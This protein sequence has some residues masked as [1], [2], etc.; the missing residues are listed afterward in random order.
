M[1]FFCAGSSGEAKKKNAK[2]GMYTLSAL[3]TLSVCISWYNACCVIMSLYESVCVCVSVM[4]RDKGF[5]APVEWLSLCFSPLSHSHLTSLQL[6][7]YIAAA[8][9]HLSFSLFPPSNSNILGVYMYC[10]SMVWLTEWSHCHY[11]LWICP[12]KLFP[13]PQ[14]S[15]F[16]YVEVH[17][18]TTL[19]YLLACTIGY[20]YI[21]IH[22]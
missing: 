2:P 7:I 14:L 13:S 19:D 18:F 20:M 3:W 5:D 12:T 21:P 10:I 4:N 1:A 15:A 16:V 11:G 17:L 22:W 6:S 9:L 8:A